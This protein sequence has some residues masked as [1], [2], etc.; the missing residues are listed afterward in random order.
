MLGMRWFCRR[1]NSKLDSFTR[2]QKLKS[3]QHI[4]GQKI[5][6]VPENTGLGQKR[7]QQ[8]LVHRLLQYSGKFL[9]LLY[10]NAV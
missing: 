3:I 10:V 7:Q 6:A 2:L 8:S 4:E 1:C 5:M 9:S